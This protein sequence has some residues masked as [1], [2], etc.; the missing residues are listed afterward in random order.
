MVFLDKAGLIFPSEMQGFR[1]MEI[2]FDATASGLLKEMV[3]PPCTLPSISILCF[4][5]FS[6]TV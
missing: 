5:H 2:R 4:I 6:E 3:G 1:V